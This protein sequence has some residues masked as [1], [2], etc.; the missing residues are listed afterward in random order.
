MIP[1]RTQI[2]IHYP[3]RTHVRYQQP[4]LR[5]REIVVHELRDLLEKPLTVEEYTR[6]PFV[7]RSRWLAKAFDCNRKVWRSFYLGCTPEFASPA[8]LRVGVFDIATGR[9]LRLLPGE[10]GPSVIDRRRL[11]RLLPRLA[12]K[13]GEDEQL[14]IFA[15]DMRLVS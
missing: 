2:K 1:E 12:T 8:V 3:V 4:P 6:R 9:L 15:P 5:E 13:I 10:F 11:C 7:R 14:G